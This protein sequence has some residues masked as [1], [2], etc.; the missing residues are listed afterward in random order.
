MREKGRNIMSSSIRKE[1]YALGIISIVTLFLAFGSAYTTWRGA[2]HLIDPTKPWMDKNVVP[3]IM[4]LVS[5]SFAASL[6]MVY[7]RI[8]P[9]ANAK[10][11]KR[12]SII[13]VF[14]CVVIFSL[15]TTLSVLGFGG[16]AALQRHINATIEAADKKL[17]QI[18]GI[19]IQEQKLVPTLE[20]LS[21]QFRSLEKSADA[22]KY[23]GAPGHGSVAVTFETM[24]DSFGQLSKTVT[25]NQERVE[26]LHQ[27]SN[28]LIGE[29][30]ELNYD[31]EPLRRKIGRFANKLNELNAVFSR[32][33]HSSVSS[34]VLQVADQIDKLM[35][36][37]TG[38]SALGRK[39]AE[40]ISKTRQAVESAKQITKDAITK[41]SSN[42]EVEI[43]SFT[44]MSAGTAVFKYAK[45]ISVAWAASIAMDFA[46]LLFLVV[47]TIV[48]RKR[49]DD[50]D[51]N[52]MAVS[53]DDLIRAQE[54][55]DIINKRK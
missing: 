28:V 27:R 17:A 31:D 38:D 50:Q 46:P 40:A 41:V 32:M 45:D 16:D 23:T 6:W 53:V 51:P 43:E 11:R 10:K 49:E 26:E 5:G 34:A 24:A 2:I 52:I 54:A 7:Y 3:M 19:L 29:L 39:Q 12:L 47:L 25:A 8:F 42:D 33:T 44:V 35:V 48:D 20:A 21:K 9:Q 15:S 55:L 1:N 36:Q 18:Y 22:G 30:R 4:A 37:S 13:L 14:A